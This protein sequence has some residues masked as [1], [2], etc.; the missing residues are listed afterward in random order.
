MNGPIKRRLMI[1]N[2]KLTF[3]NVTIFFWPGR[4]QS[5][6]KEKIINEKKREHRA[7]TITQKTEL[8][9]ENMIFR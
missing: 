7:R 5:I 3:T 9:T 1:M 8:I 4:E 6:R 2:K